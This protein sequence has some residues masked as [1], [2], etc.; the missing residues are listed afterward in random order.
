[1]SLFSL[2]TGTDFTLVISVFVASAVES[3]EAVT[4]VLAA[5]TAR[6]MR[7]SLQGALSALFSLAILVALFGSTLTNLPRETIRFI[8]GILLLFFGLQWLRKAIL[9]YGGVIALHDEA[10]IFS[11]EVALASKV[12]TRSRLVVHDWFAFTMSFKGVFLEGIEVAFIVISFAS[13]RQDANPNALSQSVVAALAAALFAGFVGLAIH[14]PLTRVPENLMKFSVGIMLIVFGFFWA[15][16]GIGIV[17]SSEF[18][19]LW[20]AIIVLIYSFTLIEY[21]KKSKPKRKKIADIPKRSGLLFTFLRFWYDFIIGDDWRM[22]LIVSISFLVGMAIGLE[23]VSVGIG[24]AL[25]L[26]VAVL[27]P[28]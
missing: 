11:E 12:T 21:V 22:P 27:S 18:A 15:L 6:H 20:I 25:A 14:K 2:F 5:G 8:I 16:E 23:I 3:V 4:I 10:K 24:V 1:M 17:W 26:I 9:R 28:R 7:S 19:L 13:V